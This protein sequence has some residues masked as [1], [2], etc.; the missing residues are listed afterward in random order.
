MNKCI[1]DRS[2]IFPQGRGANPKGRGDKPIILPNFRQNY[3]KM[4]KIVPVGGGGGLRVHI[5]TM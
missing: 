5:F 3:M 4:K 1:I 2:R